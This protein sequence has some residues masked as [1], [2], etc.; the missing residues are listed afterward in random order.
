M[1]ETKSKYVLYGHV[2]ISA[3]KI[4]EDKVIHPNRKVNVLIL[5]I[6]MDLRIF[7]FNNCP[8]TYIKHT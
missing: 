1:L 5:F 2:Q 8:V 7:H 6:C 4:F 3:L